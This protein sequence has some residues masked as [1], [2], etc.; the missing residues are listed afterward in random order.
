MK[1]HSLN[2]VTEKFTIARIL[3]LMRTHYGENTKN[4]EVSN[5]SPPLPAALWNKQ[6][7]MFKCN[8]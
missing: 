1:T 6:V 4:S 7:L 3:M 5:K 8:A 2:T